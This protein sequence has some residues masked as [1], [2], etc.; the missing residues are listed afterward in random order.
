MC[1]Y[2][3]YGILDI[4]YI[5]YVC[6]VWLLY[7]SLTYPKIANFLFAYGG[8]NHGKELLMNTKC[9]P[10]SQK[11]TWRHSGKRRLMEHPRLIEHTTTYG[12]PHSFCNRP[13]PVKHNTTYWTQHDSWSTPHH[14]LGNTPHDDLWNIPR[15]GEHTTRRFMEHTKTLETYHTTNYRT[16]CL[17]TMNIVCTIVH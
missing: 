14:D 17:P 15:L 7:Y 11:C 10:S 8:Q 4:Y 2:V 6:V 13:R 3:P 9:L 1:S 12:T 16:R 5:V